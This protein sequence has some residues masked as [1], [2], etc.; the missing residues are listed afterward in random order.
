MEH[1]YM[2]FPEG[3][4]RCLTL[5]YDDG[6]LQDIRLCGLMKQYGIAGTFNVNTG[7]YVR[8]SRLSYEKARETL[9][10]EALF[11]VATH[12][13]THPHLN[14]LPS[15]QAAWEVLADRRTIEKQFGCLCRGHVYPYGAYNEQVMAVLKACGIVYARTVKNT[16]R[17]DLPED[18]LQWHPTCHHND[19]RL[20]E[21]ADA[22]LAD[23][24]YRLPRLFY[25]WGHSFEFDDDD[26]WNRIEEFFA[27][28]AGRETVWN[29][30]NIQI[31][32]YVTAY[33]QLIWNADCTAV[34]NPTATDVWFLAGKQIYGVKAGQTLTL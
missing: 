6:P 19:P 20:M 30:T 32:D 17:F 23:T 1:I 31:F 12:S 14:R 2:R 4:T 10:G 11:E 28:T 18:F 5:S 22:F 3:R 21:L 15:A 34:H 9:G 27:K 25:L 33:G 16:G 13:Q 8:P 7:L 26:G 29:A 24:E